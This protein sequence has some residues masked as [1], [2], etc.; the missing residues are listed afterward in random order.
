[1]PG[2]FLTDRLRNTAKAEA[3]KRGIT[4]E[5]Q[6]AERTKHNPAGRFGDPEE[7]GL[8]CAFLCADKAGFITG[9]NILLDGGAFPGT[10]YGAPG[11]SSLVRTQRARRRRFSPMVRCRRRSPDRARCASGWRPP[12]INPADVGRRGGSYRA[13]E[14]PRVIPNSDGAGIIDQV[15]DGV[16]RLKIGQRV[17]LFNG[18]RNGRAFGTAA[19]YIAL[20][21]HLV[22]PLPDNLSFAQG[23]TLGIPGMTAWTCLFGDGPIAGKT[24]LVTGG[25]GAVG[26]YAVQ[27]A[28]WG[29]AQVIATVSSA[30]KAEQARLGGADLV[31]NYRN[32][33]VV[34][35]AMAFTSGRGVDRVVD[36]DFGGNI[37]TTLKLMG[38]NSTIAVYATNGNRTPI[39]ADARSDGEM[40]RAP[41]AGAVRAA[42]AAARRRA[43]RHHQMAR[44]GP[45]HPQCRRRS[46]HCRTPRRRISRSRRATS[47]A[48]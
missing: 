25:A 40:H 31:V 44:G 2:P 13:M 34:A 21:E 42:A 1:M 12:A 26:H 3:A 17:W 36:V 20:A 28:K 5:E 6:M 39:G 41:F 48:P 37:E 47:S 14:Y 45:A 23:A 38:M 30:A 4:V 24:V 46:S 8:A 43:G 18:Q 35:K 32:E 7:F 10:L 19:E 22:T 11:E 27:F 33:D 16:T 9:Q 15:G 29:G